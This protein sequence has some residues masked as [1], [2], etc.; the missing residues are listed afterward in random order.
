M[1]I[2]PDDWGGAGPRIMFQDTAMD[3]DQSLPVSGARFSIGDTDYENRPT[4]EP[5]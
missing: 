3:A 1:T 4:G 2:S 5:S